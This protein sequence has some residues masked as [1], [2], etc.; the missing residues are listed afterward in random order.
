M[1]APG[2]TGPETH[3]CTGSPDARWHTRHVP[4]WSTLPPG[5]PGSIGHRMSTDTHGRPSPPVCG[6]TSN[7]LW[8]RLGVE[9]DDIPE[10]QR[11]RACQTDPAPEAP[12]ATRD[13][14]PDSTGTGTG[15]GDSTPGEDGR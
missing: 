7:G 6:Q 8:F 5:E 3:C 1:Q 9:W 2:L 14:T 10:R 4:V 15:T 12:K 13:D 11:C